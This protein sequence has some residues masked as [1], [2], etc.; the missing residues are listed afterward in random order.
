MNKNLECWY[1]NGIEMDL[2]EYA[3]ESI[4]LEYS[5]I[6][7]LKVKCNSIRL[8]HV[9]CDNLIVD[10]FCDNINFTN[11]KINS[12]R[13]DVINSLNYVNSEINSINGN[14]IKEINGET[15]NLKNGMLKDEK[16]K[17]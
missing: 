9:E 14:E 16:K 12:M 17:K 11:C 4:K 7:N 13:C 15:K 5:H 1:F 8:T 2:S 3:F 6:N 10:G